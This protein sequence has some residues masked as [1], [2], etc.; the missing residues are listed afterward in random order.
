MVLALFRQDPW[1]IMSLRKQHLRKSHGV[2]K[3]LA[4]RF[5]IVHFAGDFSD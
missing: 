5:E 2:P 1:A 3:K 4:D